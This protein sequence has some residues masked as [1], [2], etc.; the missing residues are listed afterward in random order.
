MEPRL[1]AGPPLAAGAE[2]LGAHLERLGPLPVGRLDLTDELAASGLLGRGGAAF[3]VARKWRS[4][5]ERGAGDARLLVN[6]AEGEPL[7][8]KDRTL[9]ALRPQVVVDGALLAA[10]AVGAREIVFYIGAAQQKA[11]AAVAHALGE[12]RSARR[13][14][15]VSIRL[16]AAPDAYVAGEESA[17]V[18]FVNAGDARPTT[19]PPRPF[20]RGIAGRP[21]LV[22][23]AET[24]AHVALIARFG[25][26][27]YRAL[28][29]G[30]TPGSGLLTLHGVRA[31]GV[32]EVEF[33]TTVGELAAGAGLDQDDMHAVLLG[34]YFG[35]FVTPERAMG[36]ALD[37]LGLR[38]AGL[39]LGSGVVAFLGRSECGVRTT[40]G[41]I[42]Y[43]AAQSAAQCGPC[44]FGLRAIADTVAA[45]AN[46]HA[47]PADIERLR[48]WNTQ[49]VGRG[50]CHHPDGA[51]SLL[52]SAFDVF[53][54]EF[55][56]HVNHRSCSA[57]ADLRR[58]A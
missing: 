50:A 48:R 7:S 11:R 8:A 5:A 45:V 46:L 2:S 49:L 51:A 42:E 23:N 34:G 40:A 30:A 35:A 37:P 13:R 15:T 57:P 39:G 56:L 22:Q 54:T 17:A 6:G 41:V 12:R 25:S 20:E 4:V 47:M 24:L 10:D 21:T 18:H 27:W 55:A 32:R 31:R 19:T 38:G 53:A 9:M 36:L 1:F 58:A 28:G 29:R 3:P 26:S 52:A 43:M 16:I 14:P 33:G 44:V